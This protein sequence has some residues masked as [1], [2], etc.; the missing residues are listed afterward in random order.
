MQ[1]FKSE[2]YLYGGAIAMPLFRCDALFYVKIRMKWSF[3]KR[4]VDA[5]GDGY[6]YVCQ[7]AYEE[8]THFFSGKY[9]WHKAETW[10][11]DARHFSS[12]YQGP[13]EHD[14]NWHPTKSPVGGDHTKESSKLEFL[15]ITG[16]SLEGSL[17]EDKII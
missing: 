16:R 1:V 9:E 8:S 3:D 14:P 15:L 2:E 5:V 11:F 12:S 6:W 4:P 7:R 17:H 13:T 10:K